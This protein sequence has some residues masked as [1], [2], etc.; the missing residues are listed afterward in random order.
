MTRLSVNIN[1]IATLRNARGGNMP[2]VQQVAVDIQRFGAHGITIHP[3]PDERHIT[4]KDVELLR[5]LVTTEFNI[6]GNPTP[7]FIALVLEHKP[8]QVTLVPDDPG[9]LTSDHGWDTLKHRGFLVEVIR[10]FSEA[11]IRTSIFV[12]PD[13]RMVEGA[14]ATGTDRI[15]LYTERYVADF[16]KGKKAAITPFVEAAK[17]AKKIGLGLNAG[18]D[19]NLDNLHFFAENIPWIDEVSIGHALICDAL[20]YGLDNAVQLYLRELRIG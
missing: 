19:L 20:Y 3:R 8:E 11:G 10:Q 18:H 1:K 4:R 16:P 5:P 12:D 6:E 14:K 7:E 15:E 13:P 17:L 9:Q 2:D